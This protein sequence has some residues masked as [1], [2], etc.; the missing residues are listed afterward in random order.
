[1]TL[2]DEARS[3]MTSW[4]AG[5]PKTQHGVHRY[6]ADEFGLN[7]ALVREQFTFYTERFDPPIES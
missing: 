6:T 3:R 1:M 7:A 5:H 2:T 4:L